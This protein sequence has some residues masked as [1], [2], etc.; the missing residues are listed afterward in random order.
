MDQKEAKLHNF[1][2]ECNKKVKNLIKHEEQY[3]LDSISKND[4]DI[5]KYLCSY[6]G[7]Q[8]RSHA[9]R[10]PHQDPYRRNSLQMFLLRQKEP[11]QGFI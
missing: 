4:K 1:C 10:G 9:R 3:H 2:A 8:L 6:C 11:R 5:C 7:K